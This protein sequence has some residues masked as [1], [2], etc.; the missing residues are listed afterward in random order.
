MQV[1]SSGNRGTWFECTLNWILYFQ[2][3]DKIDFTEIATPVTNKFYIEQPHGEIYGLDHSIERSVENIDNTDTYTISLDLSSWLEELC[4]I[5][6]VLQSGADVANKQQTM[7][8]WSSDGLNLLCL[9]LVSS[10]RKSLNITALS[11]VLYLIWTWN[12]PKL[13]LDNLI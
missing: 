13:E 1:V 6:K 9:V 12:G 10:S 2:I 4:L 5:K 3:A 8:K 11:D 7:D